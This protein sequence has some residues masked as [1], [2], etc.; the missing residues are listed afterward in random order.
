MVVVVVVVA[1]APVLVLVLV[2]PSCGAVERPKA[3]LTFGVFTILTSK[4][5]SRHNGVHFLYISTSKR[6]PET[7]RF[8]H[9]TSKCAS[10]HNSVQFLNI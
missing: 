9:L 7:R 1:V 3:V 5:A 10:R 4:C 6:D 8:V 2:V